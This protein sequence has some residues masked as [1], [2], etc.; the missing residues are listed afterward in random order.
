MLAFMVY[1]IVGNFSVGVYASGGPDGY[2][3]QGQNSMKNGDY[4]TGVQNLAM[5][6]QNCATADVK[7]EYR[8]KTLEIL[9]K[10]T[11]ALFEKEDPE[12]RYPGVNEI[13]ETALR[14]D[15]FKDSEMLYNQR[16]SILRKTGNFTQAIAEY[17]NALNINSDYN[18]SRF[19][20]ALCYFKMKKFKNSYEELD[21]IP[22]SSPLYEMAKEK[23]DLLMKYYAQLIN[24]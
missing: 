8:T 21:K 9:R 14:Y 6:V 10:T 18:P 19:N 5:A 3:E 11:D 12:S 2:L 1:S 16:A 22:D 24:K 4:K 23:K 15:C 13:V 17:Q 7:K 20:L